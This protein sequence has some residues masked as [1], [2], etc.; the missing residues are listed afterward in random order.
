MGVNMEKNRLQRLADKLTWRAY[1]EEVTSW[2]NSMLDDREWFKEEWQGK[3]KE[4]FIKATML[5]VESAV[6]ENE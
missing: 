4:D 1:C 6:L 5:S 2:Y 3:T